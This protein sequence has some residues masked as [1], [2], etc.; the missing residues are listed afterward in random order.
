MAVDRRGVLGT[1]KV[2]IEISAFFRAIMTL[3]QPRSQS[4]GYLLLP[5]LLL[6][7]AIWFPT[8]SA[9]EPPTP[10]PEAAPDEG[11]EGRATAVTV[12]IVSA[13][14]VMMCIGAI[15]IHRIFRDKGTRREEDEAGDEE[16]GGC[17]QHSRQSSYARKASCVAPFPES[18][19]GKAGEDRMEHTS[20]PLYAVSALRAN[21]SGDLSVLVVEGSAIHSV[22]TKGASTLSDHTPDE[23]G[24]SSTR[25]G[26]S[27]ASAGAGA[28]VRG[29]EAREGHNV[30]RC[31][32]NE[33]GSGPIAFLSRNGISRGRK[34]RVVPQLSIES[35]SSNDGDVWDK[36]TVENGTDVSLASTVA[37]TAPVPA[38]V[39]DPAPDPPDTAIA[40]PPTR[41]T[42]PPLAASCKDAVVRDTKP[43]PLHIEDSEE[44]HQAAGSAV[45]RHT[46]HGGAS[47]PGVVAG[48]GSAARD[49]ARS[50]ASVL[51]AAEYAV[52]GAEALARDSFVP[53]VKEVV[54]LVAGLARI[55]AADHRGNA[56]EMEGRV[57]WCRSMVRT[58]ERA[59]DVLAKTTARR[60]EAERILLEDVQDSIRGM[61]E[62]VQCYKNKH[63]VT[64]VF[65]SVLCRRRQDE[66][67]EAI[68][69]AETHLEAFESTPQLPVALVSPGHTLRPISTDLAVDLR[70]QIS[71]LQEMLVKSIRKR[72]RRGVDQVDIPRGEVEVMTDEVLGVGGFGT[73]YLA[74][75]RGSNAAAKV[76]SFQRDQEGGDPGPKTGF[77]VFDDDTDDDDD[78]EYTLD[79]KLRR[80]VAVANAKKAS[81]KIRAET[82]QRLAFLRELEAMK[83]LRGP[84]T[85]HFYGAVTSTK[86][87]V[88]LVMELLPGGN[89][90]HRLRKAKGP[91]DENTLRRIVK[92]ICSGMAFLHAEAFVHGDLKSAAVLFDA[93]GNAKIGDLGT[94]LWTQ[95]TTRLAT[96]S[97]RQGGLMSLPWAA[98]E[99]LSRESATSKSDVYSFGMVL[100]EC[101]ARKLPWYN[102]LSVGKLLSSVSKGERP[103]IPP[104][105]PTDLA[106][107]TEACWAHDP[108]AR[109]ALERVLTDLDA[110]RV[111]AVFVPPAGRSAPRPPTS[112]PADSART[113]SGLT[114]ER[115]VFSDHGR[116]SGS[117][118]AAR[119]SRGMVGR[120]SR[121]LSRRSS[122]ES[123]ISIPVI[124]EEKGKEKQEEDEEDEE[125]SQE[126]VHTEHS[127]QR[128]EH[129]E[130]AEG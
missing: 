15:R 10:S 31:E 24:G 65:T 62:I 59:R 115:L 43:A 93:E 87:R 18:A 32:R 49:Q 46:I 17:G 101:L 55:A 73:V 13:V 20:N 102:V 37:V 3:G 39:P 71:T 70:D 123:S 79:Q 104:N 118:G 64:E 51:S 112:R 21:G 7:P 108:A 35:V 9:T 2:A 130:V 88:V 84:N 121:T 81:A 124:E 77:S 106:V 68:A 12:V 48:R 94:S 95:R 5:L 47:T 75:Y 34:Q 25:R 111:T 125:D 50:G 126:E 128:E 14:T 85:V 11:G 28:G 45:R 6:L 103:T 110:R 8:A 44:N 109:P 42:F 54:V 107:L 117:S 58:L 113:P 116:S 98:P 27:S 97:F 83:R 122:S 16:E 90:R 86:N 114:G 57:A 40:N 74:D 4:A 30:A 91:L 96:F 72:R 60:G 82:R 78:L 52:R 69:A 67:E 53:G 100:W 41:K 119:R 105:A 92:D 129:Q 80:K 66:A 99:V 29:S 22:S 19:E 1:I 63:M 33:S 76:V 120:G 26:M 38:P 61:A 56:A 89:L 127:E 23:A 36:D